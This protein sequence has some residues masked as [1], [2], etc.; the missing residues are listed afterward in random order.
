[1][2]PGR[3]SRIIIYLLIGLFWG[4]LQQGL[5]QN[6]PKPEAITVEDGLCFRHVN[7]IVQDK[8]GLIWV[9]TANGL[10]RYDGYQFVSFGK[11][12]SMDIPFPAL[13]FSRNG[14]LFKNDS[15]LWTIADFKL[16]STNIYSFETAPMAGIEG[17]ALKMEQGKN[18]DVWLVSDNEKNQFLWRFTE[19]NG[20]EKISAVPHLVLDDCALQ[21]DT[22]G[23]VWWSTNA[24]GL[25]HFSPSGDLVSEKTITSR[26]WSGTTLYQ[27]DFFI[28]SRNRFFIHASKTENDHQVW[29]Y[30]PTN[31]SKEIL[32]EGMSE[33]NFTA[34]EDTWGNIWFS[35]EGGVAQLQPDGDIIDYTRLAL[36]ALD[37]KN[38]NC[39]F[40]DDRN[41]LWVGTDG[42]ILKFPLTQPFFNNVF[43]KNNQGWGNA[44]RGICQ[45]AEGEIFFLHEADT[46]AIYRMKKDGLGV[47]KVALKSSGIKEQYPLRSAK[48]LVFDEK[49][50]CI[51]TMT[52]TL[53]KIDVENQRI[54]SFTSVTFDREYSTF[55]PI[56]LFPDGRILVGNTLDKM[57][58]FDPESGNI[59]KLFEDNPSKYFRIYPKVL[60]VEAEDRFW[61][62][63]HDRG[64]FKFNIE[65][66]L[67]QHYHT[68]STPALPN[69]HVSSI[70]QNGNDKTIWV[71]TLGGG[72]CL[73]KAPSEYIEVFN[74]KFGLPDNN[75]ASILGDGK[76]V[77]VGTYNGLSSFNPTEKSFRNFYAE[78]GLT[79]NEFNYASAFKSKNGQ[80]FFGGLN[81]INT[82]HPHSLSQQK[83][84]APIQV[85]KLVKYD[86]R[87]D[88][89]IDIILSQNPNQ[90]I[91]ISPSISYFQLEWTLPNYSNSDKNQYFIWTKGLETGWTF[92]GNT[93]NIRFNKLP[94][95]DY[96]LQVKGK[97]NR[98]NWSEKPLEL[99]I[100]VLA[101]WWQRWWAFGIYFIAALG[102]MGLI[103]KRELARILLQNKLKE[104]QKE[105]QRLAELD[106][107]KTRFFANISHEF[108]TPLTVILG[109][110]E[111]IK[112][113]GEPKRLIQRSGRNLL[114]LVNQLLDFSK[115][116]AHKLRVQLQAGD[117]V[118][119]LHYILENFHSLAAHKNV[120]LHFEASM[121]KLEM[122]FD[123]EKIQHI[124]S[125]LLSNAIKYTPRDGEVVLSVSTVDDQVCIQVKDTGIGI[126]EKAIARI[127]ERYFQV[128]NPLSRGDS[129]TGIGLAFT[130]ELVEL[131]KGEVE[132]ESVEGE[133]TTFR[134]LLPMTRS[135]G[136]EMLSNSEPHLGVPEDKLE[137]MDGDNGNSLSSERNSLMIIEDNPEVVSYIRSILNSEYDITVAENGDIGIKKAVEQIPDIIISDVMMPAKDG[138]EVTEYLK[139]DERTSHIPIVLLTAKADAES[140]LIGLT[141]GADAY[142]AKPFDKKE[143]RI[144]LNQ[145]ISLR[146]KLQ[147]RYA[148]F[149]EKRTAEDAGIQMEE[150]FL[151]KLKET[152]DSNLRNAEFGVQELCSAMSLSRSQ[153][154]RKLKALTGKSIVA[155]L[156]SARLHKAKELILQRK[157]NIS[158]AAFDAGFNDPLYFSRVFSKEYGFPPSALLE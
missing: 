65:G 60:M 15:T 12:N 113:Q 33:F 152:I 4:S 130:R 30:D 138:F 119:Y 137:A 91:E 22:L 94:P 71:G 97:D 86:Q 98:G 40:E 154:Y 122:D 18:N 31:D 132:V 2:A 101:P 143:L 9:G 85:T 92:L 93:P 43:A 61:V 21:I 100:L 128:D 74:Q 83:P 110:S 157:C 135:K 73:L 42:G 28:D 158:E 51:W 133:G 140:R 106:Q 112:E 68:E 103:R 10:N 99:Q 107:A 87:R 49:R 121:E 62:G 111:E 48:Y 116:G 81:G 1:M 96:T 7:S 144:R 109:M 16:W 78:D 35:K 88:T 89:L 14:A 129:G 82:F 56:D 23:G 59:E 27:A 149:E 77:W 20:F 32:L 66:D 105:A 79:H 69:N 136:I 76:S 13:N 150:A 26:E 139:N 8:S 67:L 57:C 148:Q 131:L 19:A 37:F 120:R 25:L 151:Q 17:R 117:L 80:M 155:Y 63:T 156:R 39:I 146:K 64:L 118:T 47:E 53:L 84:N 38:V 102:G 90:P 134:V 6:L 114:R 104:E 127:F 108:R 54:E 145:L 153:L 50:N 75:V 123:E 46:A 147:S 24:K 55:N 36:Q 3:T 41:T 44:M 95:G 29:L 141:R 126:S 5:A 58:I 45:N 34:T 70:Y 52:N 72:F 142:L 124:V 125:N 11:D 115:L